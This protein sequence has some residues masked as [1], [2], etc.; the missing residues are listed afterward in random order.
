MAHAS[1][2]DAERCGPCGSPVVPELEPGL[3]RRTGRHPHEAVQIDEIDRPPPG[4]VDDPT[5]LMNP[6][7]V[8][9]IDTYQ[10]GD[11]YGL[12]ELGRGRCTSDL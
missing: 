6:M 12:S 10:S 9:G 1:D 11:L 4:H 3:P 5:R 8:P 2:L 7:T